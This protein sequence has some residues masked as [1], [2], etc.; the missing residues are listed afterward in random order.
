MGGF[1]AFGKIVIFFYHL[2]KTYFREEQIIAYLCMIYVSIFCSMHFVLLRCKCFL[3]KSVYQG[4]NHFFFSTNRIQDNTWNPEL[5]FKCL[6]K[7][8]YMFLAPAAKVYFSTSFPS[9]GWNKHI[10]V[11]KMA[12]T[13][14]PEFPQIFFWHSNVRCKWRYCLGLQCYLYVFFRQ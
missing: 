1:F 8:H 2:P 3:S 11:Y 10:C 5:D 12:L 6:S 4:L 9:K 14:T 13:N 7:W